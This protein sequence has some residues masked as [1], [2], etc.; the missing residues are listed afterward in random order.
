M[1][2]Y[3]FFPGPTAL[4]ESVRNRLAS[5]LIDFNST[6]IGVGEI[7]HRSDIF[8]EMYNQL[9]LELKSLLKLE[10]E[11]EILFCT[12]GA[13][14]QFSMIP[15]NLINPDKKETACYSVGGIWSEKAYIEAKRFR[16]VTLAGTTKDIGYQKLPQDIINGDEIYYYY[17]SNNTVIGTQ[18]NCIPEIE[19]PIVCDSS[20]DF[21]SREIN[22][23]SYSLVYASA[24]K[25]LGVSGVTLVIAKKSF[26]HRYKPKDLPLMMDYQTFI[27]SNSIYNT[28]PVIPLYTI[29]LVLDWIKE[30]GGLA[31]IE[32]IN[33]RKAQLVY[34]TLDSNDFYIPYVDNECRSLM[35]VTFNLADKSF[36]QDF[37]NQLKN[38][39]FF[40]LEGHR[41]IGGYRI[42][43]Y[44]GIEMKSVTALCEFLN[45]YA[46]RK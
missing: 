18:Y 46:K 36:E 6:G 24:Q 34:D 23:N 21:L 3:N 29:K 28:P 15:L 39:N 17:T 4:P 27:T 1:R 2:I 19:L 13:T 10:S 14:Q 8:N 40:G 38:N 37:S 44:N 16:N 32:Q 7:S 33:H 31:G 25:N 12:G 11:Y 5:A 30:S 45:D 26:I 42:S 35:N 9:H 41:L 20:S 43:L 22:F